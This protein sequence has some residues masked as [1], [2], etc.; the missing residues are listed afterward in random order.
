MPKE[1]KRAYTYTLYYL[2]GPSVRPLLKYAK[3]FSLS[4]LPPLSPAVSLIPIHIYTA[5]DRWTDHGIQNTPPSPIAHKHL[6][7]YMMNENTNLINW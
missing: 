7:A 5:N 1:Q 2:N 3:R 4:S 6:K